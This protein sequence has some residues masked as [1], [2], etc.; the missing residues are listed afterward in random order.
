MAKLDTDTLR[1]KLFVCEQIPFAVRACLLCACVLRLLCAC[2]LARLSCGGAR[3][4]VALSLQGQ[5]TAMKDA[6]VRLVNAVLLAVHR[7]GCANP[8]QARRFVASSLSTGE[9]AQGVLAGWRDFPLGWATELLRALSHNGLRNATLKHVENLLP[10]FFQVLPCFFPS[11]LLPCF[12]SVRADHKRARAA[13]LRRLL[14]QCPRVSTCPNLLLKLR[15]PLSLP[16][17]L[18]LRKSR[19]CAFTRKRAR[20]PSSATASS[21]TSCTP[22]FTTIG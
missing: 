5:P 16:K 13:T 17:L 18:G 3:L 8:A 10:A 12:T 19:S 4:L 2:V 7:Q 6:R 15:N 1:A 22:F 20:P 11:F 21:S 14:S 9:A